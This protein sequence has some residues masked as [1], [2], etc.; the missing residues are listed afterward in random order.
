MHRTSGAYAQACRLHSPCALS[1][2]PI[3]FV[4]NCVLRALREVSIRSATI[5]TSH[6]AKQSSPTKN[7]L[8]RNYKAYCG[9]PDS[10]SPGSLLAFHTTQSCEEEWVSFMIL[11]P[12]PH[13]R[14]SDPI[15][16]SSIRS[17]LLITT[18][19]PKK[20]PA[21]SEMPPAQMWHL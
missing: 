2:S 18:L 1:I 19:H 9:C 11:F 13:S 17:T 12:G 4:A 8:S 20:K 15:R 3:Q 10:A 21:S 6:T 16:H 5:R 7:R 14:H